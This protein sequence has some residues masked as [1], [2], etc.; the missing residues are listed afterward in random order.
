MFIVWSDDIIH[1]DDQYILF[2]KNTLKELKETFFQ[3]CRENDFDLN[4]IQFTEKELD[5]ICL[6]SSPMHDDSF[7]YCE[8]EN[9]DAEKIIYVL[10]FHEDGEGG[11]SDNKLFFRISNNQNEL[12]VTAIEFFQYECK[13]TESNHI[14]EMLRHLNSEGEYVLPRNSTT[15]YCALELWSFTPIN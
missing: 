5:A 15:Y 3:F 1:F 7:Y 14:N 11:N 2:A 8:I 10:T 13:H 4:K 12:L 6:Y 9:V